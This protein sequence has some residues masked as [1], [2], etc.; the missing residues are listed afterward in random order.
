MRIGDGGG[1]THRR[2][3]RQVGRV[4]DD[5]RAMQFRHRQPPGDPLERRDLVGAA[6]HHG[7]Y[8]QF[9]HAHGHRGR[10]PAA[11]RRDPNAGL[12]QQLDSVP[13]A[14][15]EDFERFAARAEVQPAV[16]EHAIHIEHQQLDMGKAGCTAH[17]S[18]QIT[19]ARN[20]SCTF[21]APTISFASSVTTN[22]VM[23]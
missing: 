1:E 6:L 9:A 22:E 18:R 16:G 23:R 21:S 19:P 20:K 17:G 7:A 5:A 8:A 4:V 10:V 13:V 12:H 11:Q 2:H 3:Q 15:V 14:H